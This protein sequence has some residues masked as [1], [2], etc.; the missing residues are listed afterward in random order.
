M[1]ACKHLLTPLFINCFKD[2]HSEKASSPINV[3][4]DGIVISFN[5]EHLKNANFPMDVTDDGIVISIS[6]LHS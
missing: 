6:D 3:T 1:D 5:D 4:D 2:A